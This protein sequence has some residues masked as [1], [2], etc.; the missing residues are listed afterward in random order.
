[1]TFYLVFEWLAFHSTDRARNDRV[2]LRKGGAPARELEILCR[3]WTRKII[4]S[5]VVDAVEARSVLSFQPGCA[6]VSQFCLASLR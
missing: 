6:Q 2:G 1:M 4:R 3:I 5:D